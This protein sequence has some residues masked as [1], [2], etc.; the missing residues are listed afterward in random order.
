MVTEKGTGMHVCC[1]DLIL[2]VSSISHPPPKMS[3]IL[4]HDVNWFF[5]KSSH[6]R[7][8]PVKLYFLVT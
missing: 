8:N 3:E 1:R 2:S 4:L 5:L 7:K 6:I